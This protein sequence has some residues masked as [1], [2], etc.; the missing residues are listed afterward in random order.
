MFL[1]IPCIMQLVRVHR[2]YEI[3][4]LTTVVQD[5]VSPDKEMLVTSLFNYFFR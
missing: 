2:C 1:I 3:F 4:G 5:F